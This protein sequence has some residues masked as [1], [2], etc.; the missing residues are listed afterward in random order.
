MG[1]CAVR[2]A[3]G[4]TVPETALEL[5]DSVS[6]RIIAIHRV[7]AVWYAVFPLGPRV[8]NGRLKLRILP[9]KPFKGDFGMIGFRM[10]A[11]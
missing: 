2:I 11:V 4:T 1:L 10:P 6:S 5:V 8:L 3:V 7:V 9:V